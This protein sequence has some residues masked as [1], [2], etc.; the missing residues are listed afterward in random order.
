MGKIEVGFGIFKFVFLVGDRS[1]CDRFVL[2]FGCFV[3]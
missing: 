1:R 3:G 2:C